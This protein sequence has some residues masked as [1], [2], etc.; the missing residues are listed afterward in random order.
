MDGKTDHTLVLQERRHPRPLRY[1]LL[2]RRRRLRCPHRHTTPPNALIPPLL[3]RERTRDMD[4]AWHIIRMV[5]ERPGT[6]TYTHRRNILFFSLISRVQP[7]PTSSL[8]QARTTANGPSPWLDP[9]VG[10]GHRHPSLRRNTRV[11]GIP[12]EPH[13]LHLHIRLAPLLLLQ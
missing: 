12:P 6:S 10:L 3:R 2:Q 7:F 8:V 4:S 1:P 11:H 5:V 9:T 13:D